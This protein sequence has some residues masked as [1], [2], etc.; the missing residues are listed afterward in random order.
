MVVVSRPYLLSLYAHDPKRVAWV[1]TAA[2]ESS[3]DG[4]NTVPRN[5]VEKFSSRLLG[6]TLKCGSTAVPFTRTNKKRL[7]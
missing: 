2:F 7:V 1:L 5:Q 4:K 3:C 6:P